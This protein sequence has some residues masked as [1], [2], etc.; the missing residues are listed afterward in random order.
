[1]NQPNYW[2]RNHR[3]WLG[4]MVPH[5]IQWHRL[6]KSGYIP[7]KLQPIKDY[8]DHFEGNGRFLGTYK[9]HLKKGAK[10]VIHP[11]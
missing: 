4:M 6:L 2:I 3:V 9:I 7:S 10:P 11:Q 5:H 1:M 8:P